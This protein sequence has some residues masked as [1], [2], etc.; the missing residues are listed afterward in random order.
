M[1]WEGTSKALQEQERD[2]FPSLPA[3][4]AQGLTRHKEGGRRLPTNQVTNQG[5]RNYVRGSCKKQ[6]WVD[7][8]SVKQ[9]PPILPLGATEN[10]VASQQGWAKEQARSGVPVLILL[11]GGHGWEEEKNQGTENGTMLSRFTRSNSA[12]FYSNA[13]I[14]FSISHTLTVTTQHGAGV[15]G[16][17][18]PTPPCF[19][20]LPV[21][22][23]HIQ[24]L[25]KYIYT[26]QPLPQIKSK[27]G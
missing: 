14:I 25:F 26:N 8:G 22:Q 21:M 13:R 2:P 9:W 20:F 7:R 6:N 5:L 17:I 18:S 23:K 27:G 1:H 24:Q 4:A 11:G 3:C 12:S 10:A 19:P 16:C 15:E